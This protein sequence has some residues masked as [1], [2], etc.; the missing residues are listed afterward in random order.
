MRVGD[1]VNDQK[2]IDTKGTAYNVKRTDGTI[3][4]H[5]KKIVKIENIMKV[6]MK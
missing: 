3:S 5:N 2:Y 1:Q 6:F 4:L